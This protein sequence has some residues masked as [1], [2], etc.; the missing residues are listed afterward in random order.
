MDLGLPFLGELPLDMGVR[1][2]SDAG[3]PYVVAS[4]G[5][6]VANLF[7]S[8]A[9]HVYDGL[10]NQELRAPPTIRFED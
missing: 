1:S 6:E 5:S 2:S 8:M 9:A 4:P 10:M 7:M 3:V